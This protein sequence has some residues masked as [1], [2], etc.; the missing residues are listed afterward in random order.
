MFVVVI[1]NNEGGWPATLHRTLDDVRAYIRQEVS[2]GDPPLDDE[3]RENMERDLARL[4]G[5][6]TEAVSGSE[7][8]KETF[9]VAP[10]DA[11]HVT[12]FWGEK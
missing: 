10:L 5:E 6:A 1:S 2:D 9:Y 8:W 3:E 12:A 4:T 7:A 11:S